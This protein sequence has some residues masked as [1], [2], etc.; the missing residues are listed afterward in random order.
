[1]RNARCQWITSLVVV[2]LFAHGLTSQA[3]VIDFAH[4]VVP[5]LR[6]HCL[7]CHGE[8]KSKGGFSMNRRELFFD[9][10]VAVS[11]H[12]S[13]SLFVELIESTDP[14]M[15]MPPED[16]PRVAPEQ[17]KVL[18][19]W[20]DEGMSWE[21]GF[22]FGG[23]GW[24]PPLKPRNIKLPKA[25][26]GRD[27]PIDRILDAY[28]TEHGE[29]S[30]AQISDA[31]FLR[32]ATLDAIGLL[33]N[34]ESLT[35]FIEDTSDNKRVRMID[36]LLSNDVAYADHWLTV[37]NDLLRNDY[38]GTGFITNGRTQITTWLY[39]AL[40][41][42]MPYDRLVRELIA[43]ISEDSAGFVNGIKW[44][45]EVN[46]SQTREIQFAQ[47]ISQVFLGI[48][49]KCASCHDSFIDRWTL[50]EAYN[51]AAVFAETPLE[52]NRCDKPT[53]VVAVPKW[54]FPELGQVDP[55]A[56]RETRLQQLAELMTHS[57]NGRFTRTVINR[58][59]D[60]LMGRGIVH[61]VDAMGTE[62]WSEDLLDYL[63]ARFASDGYDLRE[64]IHF[65]MTS[66]AYQSQSVI[67]Q[68]EPGPD[69]VYTGPLAKRM[70]AEQ[71]MDSIWQ[72]TG[73]NP[74]RAEAKVDRVG[75]EEGESR[76]LHE[77]QVEAVSAKWI[78]H[79]GAVGKQ[80]Q[81]RHTFHL[82]SVPQTALM[83]TTCDNAFVMQI[84]GRE[85]TQSKEWDKP[86]YM[87]ATR[88]LSAGENLIEIDAEM[89]GGAAGFICQIVMLEKDKQTRTIIS[90]AQ[91]EARPPA[92]DWDAAKVLY[93]HGEGPWGNILNP[94]EA[95]MPMGPTSA[96]RAALVKNDFLMRSLGRPH[97]DQV[98]TTR[99]AELTT[100]QAI[101]LA[102]GDILAQ[103][104]QQGA[105]QLTGKHGL[106]NWLYR[107]A[108]SRL[109]TTGELNILKDVLGTR[110]DPAVVEDLLWLV[111]MQPEFQMIR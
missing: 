61:P 13:E 38:T 18:K 16:K 84:N 79:Q 59:W 15:Q 40:R 58:I 50:E 24:E 72:I 105:Q 29:S 108:L 43:P 23:E 31:G 68:K 83:M 75:R 25:Q 8:N 19:Q 4:Q 60:R 42:N 73:T 35:E 53:G 107:H 111:F 46:S 65:V 26:R 90:N 87:E 11:G 55:K 103:Y 109:P 98:V 69:Y 48:N 85:V 80:S 52:V 27:H 33:P 7:E 30:P 62:P 89:F 10:E 104:L 57:D 91:W 36:N 41:E 97:R 67:L 78:W 86:V 94:K 37:W 49:M 2:K 1:M 96:V 106:G 110:P 95:I 20:I 64:F 92:G 32:R 51:L 17:I 63:A 5:I 100:L 39:A 45:G 54:L 88:F 102:N 6:Q 47:N 70:T 74:S 12:A 71:F 28:L 44:R 82:Q 21:P 3:A 66:Q 9:G 34:P 99:P 81:L 76:K 77:Q 56:P 22:V 101:D 93:M 14:E